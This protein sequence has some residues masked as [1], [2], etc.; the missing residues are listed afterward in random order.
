VTLTLTF[1]EISRTR[2]GEGTFCARFLAHFC[3]IEADAT[4]VLPLVFDIV[5]N[6]V[7][8]LEEG[9]NIL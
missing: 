5:I 8:R 9:S 7:A 2:L 4:V 1:L 6:I 3:H